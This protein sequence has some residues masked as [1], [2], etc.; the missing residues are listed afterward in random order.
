MVLELEPQL[1]LGRV[2]ALCVVLVELHDAVA[3]FLVEERLDANGR[4]K[5][6]GGRQS[7]KH[8]CHGIVWVYL[9]TSPLFRV[10][11]P[12]TMSCPDGGDAFNPPGR[13][14]V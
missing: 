1:R 11:S 13:T 8:E 9:D 4:N 10:F 6:P 3:R 7:D 14:M 12:E 2:G 5:I